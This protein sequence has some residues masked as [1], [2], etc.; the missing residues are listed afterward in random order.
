MSRNYTIKEAAETMHKKRRWLQDWL[1]RHPADADGN[2]Y[3]A[4]YGRTKVLN[5]N[6]LARI[7]A[8][9]REEERCRLS[10]LSPVRARRRTI[11]R[12]ERTSESTLTAL[13][14]ILQSR[15]RKAS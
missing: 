6:D 3:Y 14:N 15:K 4:R 7:Q 2:P 5:D 1:R 9:V 10:S 13:R 8:A 12:V 11:T